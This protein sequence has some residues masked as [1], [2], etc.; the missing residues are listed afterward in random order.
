MADYDRWSVEQVKITV[1]MLEKGFQYQ[2][3]R[4]SA[5]L[6]ILGTRAQ[7]VYDMAAITIMLAQLGHFEFLAAVNAVIVDDNATNVAARISL[8]AII[9][10]HANSMR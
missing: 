7:R 5:A 6:N 8:Q 9:M 3:I 4:I 2:A 1:A 10:G